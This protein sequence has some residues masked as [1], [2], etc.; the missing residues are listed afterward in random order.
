MKQHQPIG[1]GVAE[2]QDKQQSVCIVIERQPV[3]D[4]Q[5]G[6]HG[7]DAN[8]G[9][10]QTVQHDQH[11]LGEQQRKDDIQSSRMQRKIEGQLR[12]KGDDE[13]AEAVTAV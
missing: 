5:R 8:P 9:R 7:D 1:L 3:H 6:Q 10:P 13:Q 4:P 11:K 2:D 12:Q